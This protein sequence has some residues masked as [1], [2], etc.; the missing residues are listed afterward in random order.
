MKKNALLLLLLANVALA[1]AQTTEAMKPRLTSRAVQALRARAVAGDATS[2]YNLGSAWYKG[3]A[4][5]VD[6]VAA[7]YWWGKAAAQGDA[8]AQYNLGTLYDEG[9]GVAQDHAAA[10][11]WYEAAAKQGFAFAQYNLANLY[12]DGKGVPQNPYIARDWQEKAAAQGDS[13]AMYVLS[14]L[15]QQG[16][17]GISGDGQRAL[18]AEW[19][20]K[21]AMRGNP[22][23]QYELGGRYLRGEGV[24]RS[25]ETALKWWQAAADL[26]DQEAITALARHYRD[27]G[28]R[29]QA[30]GWY[31][32][33]IDSG[34]HSAY[35]EIGRLYAEIAPVDYDEARNWWTKGGKNGDRVSQS[36]LAHS[37]YNRSN[38]ITFGSSAEAQDAFHD[39]VNDCARGKTPPDAWCADAAYHLALI[40]QF[41]QTGFEESGREVAQKYWRLAVE[42][43]HPLARAWQDGNEP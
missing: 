27:A 17:L 20:E 8:T 2:Q 40:K 39:L 42:W 14:S 18:A 7:R 19:L 29:E 1:Q 23:A 21:A 31:R 4:G 41:R 28:A 32:K 10:A 3:E 15:Y 43:G 30:L 16:E 6:Y 12:R 35:A 37:Y 22:R 26:G 9:H 24:P 5:S 36:L 33:A 38:G 34:D 25:E 11:K 13:D